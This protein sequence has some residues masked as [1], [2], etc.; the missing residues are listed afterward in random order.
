MPCSTW[1]ETVIEGCRYPTEISEIHGYLSLSQ[2]VVQIASFDDAL[3]DDWDHARHG[4]AHDLL[5]CFQMDN[6][7]LVFALRLLLR[8]IHTRRQLARAT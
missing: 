1:P 7:L 6:S 8:F 5:G 2:V 3:Q 4:L